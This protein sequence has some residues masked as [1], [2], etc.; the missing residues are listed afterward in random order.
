MVKRR[1]KRATVT[2]LP[3][4]HP[5]SPPLVHADDTEIIPD[6]PPPQELPQSSGEDIAAGTSSRPVRLYADGIFDLF[7]FGHARALEQAKKSFPNSHLIVGCCSD[8]VTHQY[9]G[10]TVMTESERYESLR[11]CKWV[12]EVVTDAPW[13]INQQFLDK[14]KVDYVTHDALPYSDASGQ[15]ND[16]Y[17]FVKKQGKFKETKRTEGISTSDII[18]RVIKNYNEYVLRNLARGYSRKDLG[19]SLMR[20]KQ[21]KAKAGMR[22]L[23]ENMRDRRLKVADRVSK[24]VMRNV[25]IFPKDMEAG[26]KDFAAGVE[27]L[28][29][30]V[31][32][33]DLGG[34]V[35]NNMDRFVSGFI[36]LFESNYS[37]FEAAVKQTFR[38]PVAPRVPPPRRAKA[39]LASK[40]S[41][42]AAAAAAVLAHLAEEDGS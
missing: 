36:R 22:Q 24:H 41:R 38:L 4:S 15:A 29:D 3:E 37:K 32:S 19:V 11:H 27:Q 1:P 35:A 42:A 12:D 6:R 13:V 9:K 23:R 18:L 31:V 39:Q 16:V 14:H 30:K 34:E 26:L 5:V 7:H 33:G 20:E 17:D 10:K 2:A 21:I 28:V 8:A 40:R 25:R